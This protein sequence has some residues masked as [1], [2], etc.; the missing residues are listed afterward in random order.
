MNSEEYQN[1]TA[2]IT[3][4][5]HGLFDRSPDL[6][7]F[8]YWLSSEDSL[9]TIISGFTASEEYQQRYADS[10]D[11]ELIASLYQ[12]FF[13]RTVRDDELQEAKSQLAVGRGL[14]ELVKQMAL[15]EEAQ[16]ALQAAVAVDT[17]YLGYLDRQ[18]DAEGQQYWMDSFE[19][20]ENEADFFVS[21]LGSTDEYTE[22]VMA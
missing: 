22:L 3:R 18:A 7:G 11:D 10:S 15:S 12:N 13:A 4:L 19:T 16:N 2:A 6:C 17:L 20:F 8:N 1:G 14:D 21:A 9:D 5:Y